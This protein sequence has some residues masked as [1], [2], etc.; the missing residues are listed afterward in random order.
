VFLLG[1]LP[2]VVLGLL[3]LKVLKDRIEDAGWLSSAQ[4]RSRVR[5]NHA[6]ARSVAS[7]TERHQELLAPAPTED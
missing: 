1:G 4:G 7:R 5:L 3:V 2:C 6:G